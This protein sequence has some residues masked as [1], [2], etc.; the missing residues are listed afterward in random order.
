[1]KKIISMA[2]VVIM[3][4]CSAV[5][6]VACGIPADYNDA[7]AN[8]EEKGYDVEVETTDIAINLVLT[9]MGIDN[10]KAD[11]V[12]NA[13][14]DDDGVML[15]YCED[16]ETAEKTLEKLEKFIEDTKEEIDQMFEDK[17]SDEYK[18]AMAEFEV[19]TGKDGKVVYMATKQG[20]KDVK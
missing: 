11:A 20:L 12:L 15:I 5:T 8:L 6:L 1:M 3:L 4:V 17:E 2:L 10:A 9:F 18:E 7:K 14:K 13:E 16:E 19:E